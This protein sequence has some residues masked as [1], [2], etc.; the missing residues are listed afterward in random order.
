MLYKSRDRKS[1]NSPLGCI[2]LTY[3]KSIDMLNKTPQVKKKSE[4]KSEAPVSSYS[5]MQLKSV[6]S[7]WGQGPS[8]LLATDNVRSI[9]YKSQKVQSFTLDV[10]QFEHN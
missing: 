8:C 7:G 9:T 1:L 10:Q 2:Q 5:Y 3:T 4:A 6:I